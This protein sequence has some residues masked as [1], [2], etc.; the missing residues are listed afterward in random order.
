MLAPRIQKVTGIGS[1]AIGWTIVALVSPFVIGGIVV[2]II[3]SMVDVPVPLASTVTAQ[4][5]AVD[6][7]YARRGQFGDMFGIVTC[8]F[9]G[10]SLALLILNIALLRKQL[11]AETIRADASERDAAKQENERH[12]F[13]LLDIH[14]SFETSAHGNV[15][16]I[17]E[18]LGKFK[19]AMVPHVQY[20]E[21]T[22]P[23]EFKNSA[24]NAFLELHNTHHDVSFT[25]L[26]SCR[27]IASFINNAQDS[28]QRKF[29]TDA[30][31]SMLRPFEHEYIFYMATL[32][33]ETLL[34][35]LLFHLADPIGKPSIHERYRNWWDDM[36]KPESAY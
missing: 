24:R 9:T 11:A 27:N 1:F 33:H 23:E 20:Y 30:F 19:S 6:Q 7:G 31:A 14:R 10:M 18:M 36:P 2:W 12:F 13:R 15:A 17:R 22:P 29:F 16:H 5:T 21:N 26:I 28:S 8:T 32:C 25:Y 4:E 34:Q 35:N 3:Y